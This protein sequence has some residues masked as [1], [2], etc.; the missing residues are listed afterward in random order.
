MSLHKIIQGEQIEIEPTFYAD[1]GSANLYYGRIRSG[2]TY[3]ATADIIEDVKR[4]TL[5][6]ATWP[7]ALECFDDRFDFFVSL[8]NFLFF[9]PIYYKIDA[10]KNFHFINAETGEVDGIPTFDAKDSKGFVRYLNTLNHCKLY[11][12]EAWRVIDSYKG[13]AV[14]NEERNLILVTGHKYREV[15]LIAQ[16]PTSIHVSARGNMGRFYKFEKISNWPWVRFRRTEYQDMTGE[17]VDETQEPISTKTYWAKRSIFRAYN[18]YFYGDLDPIHTIQFE[19]YQ[20]N[21]VARFL[22][23]LRNTVAPFR[24]LWPK[25]GP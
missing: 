24:A 2:K 15:N 5:V 21:L 3:G 14:G 25:R 11:I 22:V 17:T 6:Y 18:S 16:R 9:N 19:S 12:D 4:G 1:E 23:L 7:I 20:L 13:T 8:R 10:P